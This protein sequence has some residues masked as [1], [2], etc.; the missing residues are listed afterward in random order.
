MLRGYSRAGGQES[1]RDERGFSRW[2]R[3]AGE[4]F[5]GKG[6]AE[7][8]RGKRGGFS[9]GM[10]MKARVPGGGRRTVPIRLGDPLLSGEW[11][12]L[13][14]KVLICSYCGRA[15]PARKGDRLKKTVPERNRSLTPR[16]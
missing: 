14:K 15:R 6:E 11:S 9:T 2:I 1:H 7:L 5:I 4:S 12:Q 8:N 3:P 16:V 10:T 13:R